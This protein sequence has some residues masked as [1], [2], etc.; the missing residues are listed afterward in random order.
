MRNKD[1]EVDPH[2]VILSRIYPSS[3]D[4]ALGVFTRIIARNFIRLGVDTTTIVPTKFW[5]SDSG[6]I[7]YQ[8][9]DYNTYEPSVIRP[10]YLPF[11]NKR[12]PGL[13][14]TFSWSV[15]A[16]AKAARR[17]LLRLE[18]NPTHIYGQFLFPA[19]RTAAWLSK[20]TEAKSVVDLGESYLSF[21]EKHLGLDE[22]KRAINEVDRIVAVAD[23]L[24]DKCI[25]RYGV[26]E[27]KVATFKNAAFVENGPLD[28]VHAR[29]QLGLPLDRKI[30]GF[31]GTFDENKR[32]RYVL[33]A[34]RQ[35]PDIGAFFLGRQGTQTPVGKQVYFAGAVPH[36][37]VPVWLSAADIFVHAS[38]TEMSANAIA[39]A[40]A[41]GLPT[42]ATD[43]PGNREM[44]D[45]ECAIFVAPRDQDMLSNAIFQLMDNPKRRTQMSKA[46]L[47][48]AQRYTSLDRAR[49][50]LSWILS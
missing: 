8:I 4:L 38:L 32:P 34:L 20:E 39:E 10:G 40:Q 37:K 42:V 21:Y 13:G 50:I 41:C 35:R 30:V 24:R 26:P 25:N 46:A 7:T 48:S 12:F 19:G 29:K 17:S 11:S 33:D 16:F 14:S 45:S 9:N 31:V 44:L 2:I 6:S 18:R 1:E 15:K 3:N 47:A 23:H 28:K 43:I 27:H 36:E 49:N 5:K 22:V